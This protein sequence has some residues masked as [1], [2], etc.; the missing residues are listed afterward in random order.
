M[1]GRHPWSELMA[2]MP[3]ERRKRIKED[4]DTLH[5]EYTLSEIRRQ[6]GLTQCQMAEKLNVS[7]PAYASFEKGGNL[8]VGTLQKIASALGGKLSLSFMLD[9]D[10]FVLDFGASNDKVGEDMVDQKISR[11]EFVA[12]VAA[13]GI[14]PSVAAAVDGDG[15]AVLEGSARKKKSLGQYFTEGACWLQPQIV[16]FIK[17][18]KCHIA[19]DPFAGS[20]CLFAPVTN[21][22]ATINETAGLDID[23]SQGWPVNDSLLKI[24]SKSGA[25]IIT[26]PPYISNYSASRKRLGDGLKK[27]FD[28]TQYDDVYLLALDRMLEAQSNVVAIIPETFINSPFQKKDLLHSITILEENPFLD[29]DTPVVVVCFDS[30][31]KDYGQVKIF[32]GSEYTCTLKDVEDC[33][34]VPDNSVRMKFNDLMGWL[35][36]RCVDSTNP[37]DMLRFDF[38]EN[39]DYDWEKGIKVS[40]R[41]LTL[42][43]IDIPQNKRQAFIDSCNAI[44]KEVRDKSHDIMLSPFK[45]NMKNGV[46][47]RRLDFQTCRA[48]IEQ[49]YRK[50]VSGESKKMVQQALFKEAM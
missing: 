35:G 38:K 5:R 25:I 19:Y 10:N 42:I 21:T 9:G 32:K 24:P 4:A 28:M 17:D 27:Y 33:R 41:L 30:K 16:D 31:H 48:I 37:N 49:A 3:A 45:G 34:L 43:S 22:I 36:V 39:I 7:Q 8:R 13:F 40:S 12:E 2:E 26:N 20:G 11:R 46:R 1:S 18:S 15:R 44:L 47:R 6:A 23:P 50:S 29:T 14:V